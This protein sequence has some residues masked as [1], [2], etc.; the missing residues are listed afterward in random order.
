MSEIG[1]A[2]TA[3]HL[4]ERSASNRIHAMSISVL[5]S[6]SAGAAVYEGFNGEYG[7]TSIFTGLGL[8]LFSIAAADFNEASVLSREAETYRAAALQQLITQDQQL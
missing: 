6:L 2:K 1:Y 5:G 3:D 7:W 8:T 4:A